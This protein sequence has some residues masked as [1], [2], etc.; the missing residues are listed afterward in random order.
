MVEE[1]YEEMLSQSVAAMEEGESN[2]IVVDVGK[3]VED[4]LGLMSDGLARWARMKIMSCVK[5]FVLIVL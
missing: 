4:K 2:F 1:E 3:R 5:R